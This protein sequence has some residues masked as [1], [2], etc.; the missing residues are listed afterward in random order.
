MAKEVRRAV[1]KEREEA[2]PARGQVP[3]EMRL[4]TG[5]RFR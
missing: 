3:T 1:G 5:R 2:D 4:S